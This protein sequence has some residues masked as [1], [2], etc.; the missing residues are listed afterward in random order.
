MSSFQTIDDKQLV[1]IS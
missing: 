1:W